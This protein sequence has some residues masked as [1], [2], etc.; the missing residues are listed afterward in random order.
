MRFEAI[1]EQVWRYISRLWSGEF[2]DA[3]GGHNR[4]SFEVHLEAVMEWVWRCTWRPW[5]SEIR[6]ILRP[7]RWMV[8]RVGRLHLSVSWLSN[9]LMWQGDFTLEVSWWP[10]W[11]RRHARIWNYIQGSTCT[12]Q[13]ERKTNNVR[14]MLYL[15][16][17]VL[18]VRC[19]R[20]QLMIIA[21]TDR[22]GWRNFVFCDDGRVVDEKERDGG[23]KWERCGGYE[24]IW[25][26]RGTTYLAWLGS[27]SIGIMTRLIG[28]RTCHIGDG[29]FTRT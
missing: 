14:W 29:K 26:I 21:S 25:E 16:Y 17:D 2:R 20:C 23:W 1:I 24:R 27:P 13:N 22:E 19:T 7:G 28:T 18:D 5:S 9:M 8:R 10:N 11:W 3:L 12:H 6:T 15:V 4:A